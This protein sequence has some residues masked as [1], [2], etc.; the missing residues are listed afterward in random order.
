M[1]ILKDL[2]SQGFSGNELLDKFA[3]QRKKIKKA[4]DILDNVD[5]TL[6]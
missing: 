6:R 1:E 5:T 2:V 4:I 3:E